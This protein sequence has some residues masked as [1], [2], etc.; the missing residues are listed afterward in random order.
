MKKTTL[1]CLGISFAVWL[2]VRQLSTYS[3]LSRWAAGKRIAGRFD[4]VKG[5]GKET[6]GKLTG[7]TALRAEGI[8]DKALGTVKHGVG[9]AVASAHDAVIS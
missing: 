5:V 7:S 3:Y 9:K 4:Q 8:V 2:L 6:V 1:A